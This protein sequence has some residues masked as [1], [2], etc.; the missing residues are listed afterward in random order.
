MIPATFPEMELIHAQKRLY[1]SDG[2]AAHVIGY[3]GEV[4]ENELNTAEFIEYEQ[5]DVVGKQGIERQYNR[6]LMGVDGQRQVVVDNRGKE[7]Q[8]FGVKDAVPGK[9]LQLTIDLDVQAVAELAMDG[10]RGRGGS[11]DPRSGEVLA[12]VSRPAYDPNRFAGR[13]LAK[14]WKEIVIN[15]EK[16]MLNRA[17]Q[18][19]LAPGSTFKPLMALAGLETGVLDSRFPG[20]LPGRRELLWPVFQVP[21]AGRPRPRRSAQSDRAVL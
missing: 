13:I 6:H 20:E 5:G 4:S 16:P 21:S 15:P 7:R 14:D 11:L 17:I 1:P 2:F 8:A 12:M 19:Q 10:R 3:V 9:N 18:A